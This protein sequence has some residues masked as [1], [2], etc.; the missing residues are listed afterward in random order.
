M[1]G[2]FSAEGTPRNGDMVEMR[3]KVVISPDDVPRNAGY[4]GM[5]LYP[6]ETAEFTLSEYIPGQT[7]TAR[8][9]KIM[10]ELGK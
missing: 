4:I 7:D 6:D 1:A 5:Y 8:A 2:S 10:K 3:K 9:T